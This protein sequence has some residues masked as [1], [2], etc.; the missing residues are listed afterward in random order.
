MLLLLVRG[1]QVTLAV[2]VEV[3]HGNRPRPASGAEGLPGLKR[4][5]AV[6][7]QHARGVVVVVRGN[8][9]TLAVAVEVGHSNETG[10]LPVPKDCLA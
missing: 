7:E 9:I 6:A 2:A 4:A 3:A 8:Q 1:N 10:Q 5:V